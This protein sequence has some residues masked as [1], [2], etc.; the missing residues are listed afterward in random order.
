MH[1][2]ECIKKKHP[3]L[4]SILSP[5][6]WANPDQSW[7]YCHPNFGT[8]LFRG[9][10]GNFSM[11]S[12]RKKRENEEKEGRKRRR[13]EGKK[14]RKE[15]KKEREKEKETETE[16][17]KKEGKDRR[18]DKTFVTKNR[19]GGSN[20]EC[21]IFLKQFITIKFRWPGGREVREE[22]ERRKREGRGRGRRE[23]R[24]GGKEERKEGK[25]RRKGGEED[26]KG[27]GQKEKGKEGKG[28]AR[29]KEEEW[30]I[31]PYIGINPYISPAKRK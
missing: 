9:K 15:G 16:E 19:F 3:I 24:K 21:D 31:P 22:E 17:E 20:V 11:L 12:Q 13:K 4:L 14:R 28:D 18:K 25:K 27:K 29:G 10:K 5:I 2:Q 23:E 7:S 26:K 30:L 8:I 1:E 6:L